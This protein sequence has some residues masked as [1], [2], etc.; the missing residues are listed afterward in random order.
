VKKLLRPLTMWLLLMALPVSAWAAPFVATATAGV[1]LRSG[2]STEHSIL[3]NLPVQG[4]PL[5]VVEERG[6]WIRVVDF[7]GDGGWV[8]QSLVGPN[9]ALIVTSDNV[10]LR[11]GP[12]TN[13]DIVAKTNRGVMLTIVKKKGQWLQVDVPGHKGEA[14]IFNTLCWGE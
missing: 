8:A 11:S 10:N 2:P 4:Y 12:G 7:E 1:N 9:H 6:D 14:W 3:W 13:F 5:Q